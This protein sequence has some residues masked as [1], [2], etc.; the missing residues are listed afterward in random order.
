MELNLLFSLTST[1]KKNHTLVLHRKFGME[2]KL[3]IN[4][5]CQ[6]F[7]VEKSEHNTRG[8]WEVKCWN[9]FL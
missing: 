5:S 4:F 9:L 6:T 7:S 3:Q 8:N 2:P 1:F